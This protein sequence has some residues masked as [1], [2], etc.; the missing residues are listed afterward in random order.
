MAYI[1]TCVLFLSYLSEKEAFLVLKDTKLSNGTL[2]Q[3]MIFCMNADKHLV[4][5]F[6]KTE[7]G[8]KLL[9]HYWLRDPSLKKIP[10][11][12]LAFLEHCN[13]RVSVCK[14]GQLEIIDRA[15][16]GEVEVLV[17]EELTPKKGYVVN[18]REDGY[19]IIEVS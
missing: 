7:L 3:G 14:S 4:D 11:S 16:K 13:D 9:S 8:L 18:A 17:M 5:Y 1:F 12:H 6:T 15:A 2:S 10:N 19:L